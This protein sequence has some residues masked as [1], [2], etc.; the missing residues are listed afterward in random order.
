[1]INPEEDCH[2]QDFFFIIN[3]RNDGQT[4][5]LSNLITFFMTKGNLEKLA[6]FEGN[7]NQINQY[8]IEKGVL[9][10]D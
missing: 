8:L 10:Y 3:N 9:S 5:I 1:M 7:E 2:V 4:D 6:S